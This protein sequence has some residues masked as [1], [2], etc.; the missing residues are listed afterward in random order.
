MTSLQIVNAVAAAAALVAIVLFLYLQRRARE[1]YVRAQE[2]L[3]AVS[4]LGVDSAQLLAPE[5][6][7]SS[8]EKFLEKIRHLLGAEQAALI[9]NNRWRTVLPSAQ[10]GF[11]PDLLERMHSESLSEHMTR[12]V[13]QQGGTMVFR[14]GERELPGIERE[15]AARIRE[16]LEHEDLKELTAV[17]LHTSEREFGVM[18]LGGRRGLKPAQTKLLHGLANQIALTLENYVVMYDAQRRTKEYELLTQIGQVASSQLDPDE[19]LRSIHKGLGQLF[20]TETFYVAFL[21]DDS[22]RFD[23]HFERGMLQA[24][25]SRPLANGLSEHIIRTA[26]PMLVATEMEDVRGGIGA[27]PMGPPAKSFVGVPVIMAGKAVG[28]MAAMN[29]DREYVYEQRDLDMLQT[30]AGQLSVAIEN[31]RRFAEEQR[32]AQ[33]LAFLNSISKTAISS[34][35]AEKMLDD[36]VSDIQ[37]NFHFEHIGIGILDYATKDIEIKAEAGATAKALG[38]RVPLGVG[39]LGRVA[40][41]GEMAL[42]QN[43]GEGHLLGVVPESRSVLCIPITYGETLMGV[44]NVESTRDNAFAQPEILMLRT[45]ADLLATALH[46]AYVFQKM[47][48]QSITDGL[49]GIKTRRFFLEAVQSE[50][51]RASR[52]GR[53]FSV[54]LIDLDKFKEVNDTMGHLEGDLVLARIGRLLEQKCRQSN[55]VARY[56]GD[57]FVILMPETGTEQA[58]ILS[59]RLRLWIATDPMLNERHITGSF[60]VAT[61]PLHGA[62]VEDI[63]RVADAGMY[64][65]KHAGGNR[66]S[67]AEEF[68]EGEAAAQQRQLVT[69]YVEGFLQREHVGPEAAEEL[70]ASLRKLAGSIQEGEASKPLMDA[71]RAL[72]RAAETR[73]VHAAGH[74]EMVAKFAESI[75]AELGMNQ[76]ELDELHFVALVH[77]VGKLL[78]PDRLLNKA[79]ALTPEEYFVVKMHAELGAQIV[80][81][82]PGKGRLREVVR[83]H[84]ERFDGNGYPDKL[85]G[86]QIPLAARIIAVAEAYVNM[87]AERPYAPVRT[88]SEAMTELETLSGTQFD[89]MLVRLLLRQLRGDKAARARATD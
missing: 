58:Q 31:A 88:A 2:S 71:V 57:E 45:L 39:I 76:D 86:E 80:E 10:C 78:I 14:S 70:V 75:G 74:G 30:A 24:K 83:H 62:T 22:L 54:V 33:Y 87:T 5:Q 18:L 53:P 69:A 26:Q 77:D 64:V 17:T 55:V 11:W 50:W 56:G 40:R 19:V 29:Y 15:H 66:V 28:V 1:R 47:Q 68:G 60:G 6:V 12:L 43:S 82:I 8:L 27:R 41:T 7:E 20:D 49:T 44:L 73:E 4:K 37:K 89:G 23:L 52:S 32:R 42:V 16:V 48:Q 25:H 85:R 9:V 38:R 35:N 36:I 61:F 46:N 51:K 3:L 63:V 13:H 81:T 59:E 79:G 72:T 67:T 34:Q 84:H 65:S 21:E